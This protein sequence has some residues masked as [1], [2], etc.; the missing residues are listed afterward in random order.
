MSSTQHSAPAKL[1]ATYL[2]EVAAGLPGPR[3]CRERILTELRDGLDDAIAEHTTAGLPTDQAVTAA[4]DQFGSPP[5]IADAFTAELATAYARRTLAWFI[6]TGPL[7]GIWWLLLLHP[8]PW[9][10]GLVALLAAIPV[11]PLIVVAIATAAGTFATTG[12]LMRWLPETTP[13]RAVAATIAVA[14]LALTGDT[15]VIGIYAASDLPVQPLAVI[16]VATSL[17]RIA[18]SLITARRGMGWRNRVASGRYSHRSGPGPRSATVTC[19]VRRSRPGPGF[20]AASRPP[21]MMIRA[22]SR[23]HPGSAPT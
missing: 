6:V 14:A 11:I 17:T 19:A 7:V 9:R 2:G 13:Q 18:C 15:V 5:A 10:T 22:D 21:N 20:I 3:R 12:R 8:H 4:I 1:L 23:S 16:A